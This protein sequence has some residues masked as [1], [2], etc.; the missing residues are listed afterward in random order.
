MV[1]A[2]PPPAGDTANFL[3]PSS[4]PASQ[5]KNYPENKKSAK[6]IM[7]IILFALPD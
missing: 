3:Y 7:A 5:N 2:L 1:K 6:S 4:H